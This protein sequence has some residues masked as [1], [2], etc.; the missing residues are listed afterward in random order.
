MIKLGITGTI[1]SGKTSVSILLKRRGIPVFNSDQYAKMAI[2]RGNPC[3]G[4]LIEILGEEAIGEDGDIQKDKMASVIFSNE[5]K[6]LAVNAVVHPYVREGMEHFFAMRKEG[7]LCAAE[8]PLLFEA[9]YEDAFDEILVVTCDKETA[10][11]RMMEDRGYSLE[12][13]QARYSRQIDPLKQV[14][15][16]DIVLDNSGS[17]KDL[18]RQVNN[19]IRKYRGIGTDDSTT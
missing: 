12:E 19:L 6:R 16:A 7:F 13:A 3:F 2:H 10:I 9:G 8:V 17:L 14:A 18:D 4:K 15:K 1:A 5:D 11:K